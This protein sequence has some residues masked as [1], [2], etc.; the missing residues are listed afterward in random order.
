MGDN[1]DGL[2]PLQFVLTPEEDKAMDLVVA[3]F[4][5]FYFEDPQRFL[6]PVLKKLPKRAKKGGIENG[7]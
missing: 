6:K 5:D 4:V 7:K 2:I 3:H 1:Q